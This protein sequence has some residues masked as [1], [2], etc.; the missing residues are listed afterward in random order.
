MHSVRVGI[1]LAVA[2]TGLVWP[3][4]GS[5]AVVYRTPQRISRLTASGEA[6]GWAQQPPGKPCFNVYRS[7]A[8]GMAPAR[9][10]R[11]RY[12]TRRPFTW[13]QPWVRIAGRAVFWQEVGFGNTELVEWIRSTLPGGRR[14][15]TVYVV[16]C[17]GSH[18]KLLGP[19]ADGAPVYSVFDVRTD[20]GCGLQSGTGVVRRIVVTGRH[21]Q[22]VLV[23]GAPGAAL[24]A[25]AGRSLLEVPASISPQGMRP[26]TTLEL[27]GLR[28]GA[29]RW[30]AALTGTPAAVAVSRSFAAVLVRP[31]SGSP[32]IR[33]YGTGSGAL[34]RSLTV[35]TSALPMLAMVGPRVVLAYPRSVVVWNVRTNAVHRLRLTPA[36]HNLS[37][38]GRMVVWNT[39]HSIRSVTVRPLA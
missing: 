34:T 13:M 19:M 31:G 7:S 33:A 14:R 21:V 38:D 5:G 16:D 1:A 9:L 37:A 28:S 25:T 20:N 26:T 17:G 32:V 23:P 24:I 30:S 22:H 8:G 12:G 36:P 39:P 3:A 27:R 18:G 11:C 6:L 15:P 4:A 35:K 10:T 29:E 2:A